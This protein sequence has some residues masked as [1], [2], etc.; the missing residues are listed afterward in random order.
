MIRARGLG[1]RFGSRV[2]IAGLDLEAAD[3]E[4]V[5]LLGPNGAGK[6]TTV[7][8]LGG[9]IAPS[10]GEAEVAGL[11]VGRDN[12]RIRALVGFL[13]ETP[14]LY[15]HLTPVENL[16]YFAALHGLAAERGQQRIEEL[17]EEFELS[18]RAKDRVGGFSKGMRQKVALARALL[19]EPEVLFLD[20]PTSGLDPEAARSV[21]T[22]IAAEAA[23]GRTILLCTHNLDEAARLCRRVFV[24]RGR[25][26]GTAE[27]GE[28]PPTLV[29]IDGDAG[30][31]AATARAVAGVRAVRTE[32]CRLEIEV[33][34]ETRV[35]PA[36]VAALVGAGAR[37]VE[38]GRATPK[39]EELYFKLVGPGGGDA[40]GGDA[41]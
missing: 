18:D 39:V 11:Q 32:A 7:R 14:G 24:I 41:A 29:R 4:V 28:R 1:K 26:L 37:I 31:F 25:L 6:T 5:G 8:M 15:D 27:L 30:A 40:R 22:L 3:G 9:L 35:H 36:L 2:A 16:A 21:R 34:D 33:E 10:E 12:D 20:E 13:T 17:L 23:K 19:H 38:L